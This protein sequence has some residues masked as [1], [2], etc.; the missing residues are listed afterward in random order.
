M[1]VN[2]N[3]NI[4]DKGIEVEVGIELVLY[5][6]EHLREILEIVKNWTC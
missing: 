2:L 5:L 3:N 1:F 4:F 6:R